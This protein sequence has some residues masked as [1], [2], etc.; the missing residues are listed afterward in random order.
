[1]KNMRKKLSIL[2]V[3]G[4][5]ITSI[6]DVGI[7]SAATIKINKKKLSLYVGQTYKLKL[8]KGETRI[9]TKIKW[10]STNKKI[11]TVNSKGKVKAVGKGRA[12]VRAKFGKR[13]FS[14]IVIVKKKT[15]PQLSNVPQVT[16]VNIPQRTPMITSQTQVGSTPSNGTQPTAGNMAQDTPQATAGDIPV[17]TPRVTAENMILNTPQATLEY[18][19]QNTPQITSGYVP[20]NTPQ[21][22]EGS[23]GET[24]FLPEQSDDTFIEQ[25]TAIPDGVKLNL[26]IS[27]DGKTITGADNKK[28]AT[29]AVIP[30]SV[31]SIEKNALGGCRN[32]K[33]LM[34]ENGNEKYI[35]QDNCV[36]EKVSNILVLGCQTSK[37]PS[38]VKEI[39]ECAFYGCSF[40]DEIVLP[41]SITKIN[42][43]AFY[44]CTDLQ[45]IS[46]PDSVI[47][48]G[49]E[50]GYYINY[51][52]SD[53]KTSAVFAYCSSLQKVKLPKNLKVINEGNFYHCSNLKDLSIPDD[54]QDIKMGAFMGCDSLTEIDLPS[55]LKNIGTDAFYGCDRLKKISIPDQVESVGYDAFFS[56]DSLEEV[57][58]CNPDSDIKGQA[59]GYCNSLKSV[60]L[61]AN[62]KKIQRNMFHNCS[63]LEKV[64]LPSALEEVGE[65]AFYECSQL[66]DVEFSDSLQVIGDSAFYGCAVETL[67]FPGEVQSIGENA[68]RK[69]E[70]LK[71]VAF[72][73]NTSKALEIYIKWYAFGD[74]EA[75]ESVKFSQ[76]LKSIWG[77]AFYNTKLQSIELPK[78]VTDV[79]GAFD[80]CKSLSSI[81]V[82]PEN[83]TYRV[84]GNCLI[85]QKTNTVELGLAGAVIPDGIKAIGSNAFAG[86]EDIV[87]IVIPESV[88]QIWG[89]AFKNCSN[90][91]KINMPESIQK[92]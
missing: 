27:G 89:S 54:V 26:E 71:S 21:G 79:S 3:A 60:S 28:E 53:E 59:F 48:L 90:L 69:C 92:I 75:L 15:I 52:D 88:E 47:D 10:I 2:L 42:D 64:E 30:K 91:K 45:S 16:A 73:E 12:V 78:N 33:Q 9:N 7:S 31:T 39:G 8:K 77:G 70:Q 4:L 57:K 68:F 38:Y 36:I 49:G 46:I 6:S 81:T 1:M 66:Q 18:I 72:T 83:E 50:G 24:T 19:P 34:V 63:N 51:W 84:E 20:Q 22:T 86:R 74:C 41:D 32:L 37:I 43:A 55:D 61:P 35:S 5:L 40:L 67:T 44:E 65:E 58:F 56:C 17:N 29:Y 14:C 87:E 80:N 85:N 23:T 76:G 82:V 62:L 13:K 11:V 25:P